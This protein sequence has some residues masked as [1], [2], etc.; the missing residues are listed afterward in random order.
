MCCNS[1][2]TE[3]VNKIVKKTFERAEASSTGMGSTLIRKI[4]ITYL[5]GDY[6]DPRTNLITARAANHALA[7]A[8]RYYDKTSYDDTFLNISNQIKIKIG[9]PEQVCHG[10]VIPRALRSRVNNPEKQ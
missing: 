7:T 4:L 5:R 6:Q 8:D 10:T 3:A 9:H 1:I 2:G